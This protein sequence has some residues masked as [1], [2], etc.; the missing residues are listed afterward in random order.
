MRHLKPF[1]ESE[2]D[3]IGD[4]DKIGLETMKGWIL[5]LQSWHPDG[6][7]NYYYVCITAPNIYSAVEQMMEAV[8]E[9]DIEIASEEIDEEGFV[10]IRKVAEENFD[11][12][13]YEILKAWEGLIPRSNKTNNDIIQE[14][15]PY[16]IIK[17]LEWHYTNVSQI[18]N[19]SP[20]GNI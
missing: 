20:N 16:V 17:E 13:G 3:L 19:Q 12:R 10:V 1:N 5:V 18:L 8:G 15:N 11:E 2:D 4:L 14:T 9:E 6:I 7:E